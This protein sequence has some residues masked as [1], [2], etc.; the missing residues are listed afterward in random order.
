M[1]TLERT[2][3]VDMIP[4]SASDCNNRLES[5]DTTS[6]PYIVVTV[7]TGDS[8][9]LFGTSGPG[10]EPAEDE[11]SPRMRVLPLDPPVRRRKNPVT[12]HQHY[13]RQPR[14]M[15]PGLKKG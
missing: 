1:Q 5:T 12:T 13:R 11:R 10:P 4:Y 3:G 9:T 8:T 14:N 15:H 7:S 6:V 2:A